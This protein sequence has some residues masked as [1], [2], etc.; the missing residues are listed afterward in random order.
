MCVCMYVSLCL[1]RSK[2]CKLDT[3]SSG[4]SDGCVGSRI[5]HCEQDGCEGGSRE[6]EGHRELDR[7]GGNKSES[8]YQSIR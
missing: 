6:K 2:K 4:C 5:S 1:S 3:F 7:E 8:E